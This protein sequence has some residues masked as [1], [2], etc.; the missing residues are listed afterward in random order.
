MELAT[1]KQVA[2][3]LATAKAIRKGVEKAKAD[4]VRTRKRIDDLVRRVAKGLLEIHH[5]ESIKLTLRERLIP[6][7][8]DVRDGAKLTDAR[9]LA[10]QQPPVIGRFTSSELGL[11]ETASDSSKSRRMDPEPLNDSTVSQDAS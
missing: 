3:K 7:P 2:G 8:A 9:Y 10:P 5:G 1:K 4:Y 11:V 6:Y